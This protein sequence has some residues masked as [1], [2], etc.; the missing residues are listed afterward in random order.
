[1]AANFADDHPA[2]LAGPAQ[3]KCRPQ[4]VADVVLFLTSSQASFV[5]GAHFNVDGGY[6]VP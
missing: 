3:R 4:E 6:V 2:V 1:M 5:Q